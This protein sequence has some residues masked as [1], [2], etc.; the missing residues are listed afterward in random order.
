MRL[1]WLLIVVLSGLLSPAGAAN[2]ARQSAITL[3]SLQ[4][5][6]EAKRAGRPV[7]DL[8]RAM[9]AGYSFHWQIG[10]GGQHR[11]VAISRNL[12]GTLLTFRPDGS[13][14]ARRETAEVT[15]LQLFDFD[16]DGQAE[17]ILEEIDG[18]GTGILIKN[19]HIYRVADHAI[20]NLWQGLS[21]QRKLLPSRKGGE[22]VLDLQRGFVRCEPSGG[23]LEHPRLLHLA[24]RVTTRGSRVVSKRA[25]SFS[26]GRFHDVPWTD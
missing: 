17:V 24:E 23:G 13:I 9:L 10:L 7:P 8:Y 15:W 4:H 12:G 21:Y 18:R 16:E 19:F 11:L 1:A 6:L 20:T 26:Q 5:A 3:D 14:L 22:P 25:Y 2:D